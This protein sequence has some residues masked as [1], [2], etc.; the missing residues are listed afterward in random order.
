MKQSILATFAAAALALAAHADTALYFDGNT[1]IDTKEKFALANSV[2]L[3]AWIRI[4]PSIT[5]NP[6]TGSGYPGCG[7]VGQG[8]FG[9]A[10]GLGFYLSTP[11]TTAD[12]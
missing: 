1:Y 8:Y 2:S 5:V 11:I 9:G 6:P 12:T 10:T 7:I 3:S 4:S